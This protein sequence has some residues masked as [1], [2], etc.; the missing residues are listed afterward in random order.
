MEHEKL[1]KGHGI[2]PIPPLNFTKCVSFLL[3]LGNLALVMNFC[4]F[5]PFPQNVTNAD[6]E[7]KDGHGN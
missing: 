4:I 7:Q 5:R 1:A 6:F 3:T 2:L